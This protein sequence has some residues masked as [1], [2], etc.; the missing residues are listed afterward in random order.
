MLNDY[1]TT[2]ELFKSLILLFLYIYF[3]TL[4]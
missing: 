2:T 4:F 3:A 1:G